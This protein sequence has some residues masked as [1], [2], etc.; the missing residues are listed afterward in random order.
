VGIEDHFRDARNSEGSG[1]AKE[2]EVS[3]IAR[4]E[5]LPAEMGQ[6]RLGEYVSYDD[7]ESVQEELSKAEQRID[8][9]E[10]IVANLEGELA[11]K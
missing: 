4:F 9:L 3:N 10:D 7:F 1:G 2:Y 5:L 8:E 6:T 11:L